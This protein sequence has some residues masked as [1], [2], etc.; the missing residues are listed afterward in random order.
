MRD[1]LSH[2]SYH[3][4]RLP[5]GE[6]LRHSWQKV[7]RPDEPQDVSSTRAFVSQ[8]LTAPVQGYSFPETHPVFSP[9]DPLLRPSPDSSSNQLEHLN[10][11]LPNEIQQLTKLV[12]ECKEGNAQARALQEALLLD[13][14]HLKKAEINQVSDLPSISIDRPVTDD[15]FGFRC[16]LPAFKLSRSWNPR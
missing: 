13:N 5:G 10:T 14:H 2:L 6:N 7:K 16:M 12:E 1:T 11:I 9:Q 3:Y 15:A 8:V 4:G